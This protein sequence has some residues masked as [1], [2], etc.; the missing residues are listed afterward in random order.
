MHLSLVS[1]ASPPKIA[2]H[3]FHGITHAFGYQKTAH[4]VGR[5]GLGHC[6][7]D[8]TSSSKREVLFFP[9]FEFLPY[10]ILNELE[11]LVL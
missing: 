6:P 3:F 8:G 10:L 9:I 7:D 1:R 2:D 4:D 5:D 11:N